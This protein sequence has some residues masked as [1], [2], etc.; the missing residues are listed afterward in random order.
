MIYTR[1]AISTDL[2]K[3]ETDLQR[4]A[5]D[6]DFAELDNLMGPEL[7]VGLPDGSEADRNAFLHLLKNGSARVT[8]IKEISRST[9]R[10][11]QMGTTRSLMAVKVSAGG[12][13]TENRLVSLHVW[14]FA[15]E[16]WSIVEAQHTPESPAIA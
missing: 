10:F 1:T 11:G 16:R 14:M 4:A 12:S 5:T 6:S 13:E 15:N 2:E 9:R 3:A 8:G 7:V